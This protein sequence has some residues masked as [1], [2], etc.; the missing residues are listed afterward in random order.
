MC[1][2]VDACSFSRVF[3][4]KTDADFNPVKEWLFNGR[5]KMVFGGSTYAD[6][7]NAMPKYLV[8]VAELTRSGKT[9]VIDRA[10]VDATERRIRGQEGSPDF[11]DPHLVAIV[12]ESSCRVVC[13]LDSRSDR[14]LRDRRFYIKARRPSIYRSKSHAHLLNNSNI[15]GACVSGKPAIGRKK[16]SKKSQATKGRAAAKVSSGS[17][18]ARRKK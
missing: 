12:E 18:R 6:E 7:L 4:K 1:L 3:A 9:V 5:G 10:Q 13:T 8:F 17:S 15:V 14:F 2:V 16:L 11:D